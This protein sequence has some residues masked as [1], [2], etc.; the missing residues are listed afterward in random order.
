MT[1]TD[2]SSYFDRTPILDATTG[3]VLFYGQVGPFDD[4]KRDA[5]GAYRRILSVA[6]GTSIPD[7]RTVRIF[8]QVWILG[9]KEIDGLGQAH[10]EKYVL[11]PTNALANI[12][13]MSAFLA[14]TVGTTV[15][16]DIEWLK[17]AKEEASSSR[18][19]PTQ[20]IYFAD[21]APVLEYSIV[22]TAAKAYLVESVRGAASGLLSAT[23]L[24]LEHAKVTATLASRAYDPVMGDFTAP[25][26]SSV[27]CQRVRWQS[28]Y[29]Y[30]TQGTAKYQEG[31]ASLVLPAGTVL[32]TADTL[33]LVGQVWRVMGVETIG[34]AVVAHARLA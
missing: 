22:W 24:A 28:L 16:C 2:A 11:Q 4:S 3:K 7:N 8:A 31:D 18:P 30:D 10:R 15:Y 9:F 29:R 25:S 14:G 5:I 33:T 12:S 13:T 20:T 34:G 17:D 21:G 23:A 6:P 26:N 32:D 1:L 27:Q 19:V